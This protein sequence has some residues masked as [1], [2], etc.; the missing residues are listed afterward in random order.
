MSIRLGFSPMRHTRI[1][2]NI[3]GNVR[4]GVGAHHG[5]W[6]ITTGKTLIDSRKPGRSRSRRSN[7]K[8]TTDDVH[9]AIVLAYLDRT[10]AY[11]DLARAR[12][13]QHAAETDLKI[14]E[15][16]LALFRKSLKNQT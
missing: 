3:R 11:Q 2:T 13:A 14:A 16:R 7:A 10:D 8:A 5:P 12:D 4:L 9:A 1:S 15:Q 6:S